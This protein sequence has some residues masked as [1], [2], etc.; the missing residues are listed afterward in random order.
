MIKYSGLKDE[1]DFQVIKYAVQN[2]K[3]SRDMTL[4]VLA[5]IVIESDDSNEDSTASIAPLERQVYAFLYNLTDFKIAISQQKN[6]LANTCILTSDSSKK[7]SC[8]ALQLPNLVTQA[9]HNS[10]LHSLAS[11]AI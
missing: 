7:T 6:A 9:A 4:K 3:N 1:D 5:T 2:A 11:F 10:G 8:S